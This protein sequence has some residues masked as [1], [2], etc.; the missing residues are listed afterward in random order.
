MEVG[1][2]IK[3]RDMGYFLMYIMQSMKDSGQMINSMEMGLK[4]GVTL[5]GLKQFIQ[6]GSLKE[7]RMGKEDF[8]GKMVLIMKEILQT[9]TFKASVD[10]ILR[11]QTNIMKENL[12]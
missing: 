2:M 11:T 5:V 1:K 4:L 7:G 9:G 8:N 3:P 12:G 6:E 10:I